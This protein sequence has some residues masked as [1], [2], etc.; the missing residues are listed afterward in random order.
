MPN[1]GTGRVAASPLSVTL[2]T[3]G[4]RKEPGHRIDAALRL[5][6]RDEILT[7]LS[8]LHRIQTKL[9]RSV[10]WKKDLRG[11]S[12]VVERRNSV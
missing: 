11:N 3:L 7:F 12:K 1:V 4:I 2:D 8:G 10:K 6:Q 9:A 5:R